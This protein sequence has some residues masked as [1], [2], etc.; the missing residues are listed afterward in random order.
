[1]GSWGEARADCQNRRCKRRYLIV[2]TTSAKLLRLIL[3]G[4]YA[5]AL[6]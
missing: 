4:A 1:M 3:S 6:C 2:Y 5:P